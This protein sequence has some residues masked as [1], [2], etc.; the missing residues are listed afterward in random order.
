MTWGERTRGG[1]S[2][3]RVA[4]MPNQ[5]PRWNHAGFPGRA[6]RV[7]GKGAHQVGEHLPMRLPPRKVSDTRI[8]GRHLGTDTELARA[9]RFDEADAGTWVRASSSARIGEAGLMT[10]SGA[11]LLDV[12]EVFNA[13][14]GTPVITRRPLTPHSASGCLAAPDRTHPTPRHRCRLTADAGLRRAWGRPKP[15]APGADRRLL[16][17][18]RAPLPAARGRRAYP[19]ARGRW[20][21]RIP[22]IGRGSGWTRRRASVCCTPTSRRT[23]TRPT[24][25]TRC[26]SRSPTGEDRRS[27][28][29]GPLARC[30]RERS[31]S[32]T[33]L[34]RTRAA[35][36]AAAAGGIARS[37]WRPR[38]SVCCSTPRRPVPSPNSGATCTR[39]R[40]SSTSS[41]TCIAR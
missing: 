37:T 31:L 11:G 39:T 33:P 4:E 29:A 14:A 34:S 8:E 22:G 13:R 35:W 9:Q 5:S 6:C 7:G 12:V 27:R 10:F 24:P 15:A 18:A 19:G 28:P 38:P 40:C 16:P 32:S 26:W 2:L 25:T 20:R 17:R 30:I 1:G 36:P 3:L 41:S 21:G 23:S